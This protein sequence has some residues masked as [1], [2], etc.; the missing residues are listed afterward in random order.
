MNLKFFE[1]WS[2]EM[3]YVLGFFAADGSMSYDPR[4]AYYL[5]FY[6]NDKEILEKIRSVLSSEHKI[7]KR[8]FNSSFPNP[9]Y[10]IQIGSKKIYFD[11]LR[12]G[13]TRNKSKSLKF[14]DVPTSFL[15]DFVR[16]YFDGDGNILSKRYFRKDRNKYK[17]YFAT[18]FISG[19][20]RFLQVLRKK[21]VCHAGIGKGSFFEG[22]RSFVLSFAMKDSKRLCAFMYDNIENEL[23][24]DRKYHVYKSAID[25]TE[26]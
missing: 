23:Y 17:D 2:A 13:M 21:L 6:S 7:S 16:G 22:T 4:G 25:N 20:C 19:S 1:K 10:R 12:L 26:R 11:L 15:R 9:A 5:S 3:A 8:S 18:K 24:L 14:P